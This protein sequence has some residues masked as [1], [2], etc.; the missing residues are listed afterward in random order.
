MRGTPMK[1]SFIHQTISGCVLW[2]CAFLAL[3]TRNSSRLPPRRLIYALSV[4]GMDFFDTLRVML[5][6]RKEDEI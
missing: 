4:T 2:K 3:N 6:T 1:R 5:E